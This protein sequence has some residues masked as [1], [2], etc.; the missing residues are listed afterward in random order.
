MKDA[1]LKMKKGGKLTDGILKRNNEGWLKD[2]ILI[3]K[4]IDDYEFSLIKEEGRMIERCD[5]NND[6]GSWLR[7]LS[8]KGIRKDDWRMLS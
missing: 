6:D 2:A 8:E 1:I 7:M 5:F 4:K 3:I